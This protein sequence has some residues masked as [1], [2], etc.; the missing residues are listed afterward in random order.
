[1]NQSEKCHQ[2]EGCN[3]LFIDAFRAFQHKTT[4]ARNA[5]ILTHYHADHW[6]GL[7]RGKGYTGPSKIHCTPVTA[8]LLTE[9]HKIDASFIVTHE[10]ETTWKH[11]STEITFY[12]ANHCPGAA[13][14]F[15]KVFTATATATDKSSHVYRYHLHTG[16]MRFHQKFKSYPLIK[17]AVENRRLDILYLDTTYAKPKHTFLP[18]DEAIRKISSQVRELLGSNDEIVSEKK[19]SFFQPTGKAKS[20]SMKRTLV[21]LSCYSIGKEKVLWHSALQS[22]QLVYVNKAKHKMLECIECGSHVEE[23]NGIIRRC[24]LDKQ[25][26]D[27]HVIQ[28]G[29]AGSLHPYFQPNFDEC[30]LYAHRMNKGYTKVVAFIPTGWAESSKYNKENAISCK[31]VNLKELIKGSK[32]N[33]NHDVMQV[34]VR[35]C[36][37]SE[38]STYTELRD[39]VEF[40]R[41]K[42]IIPTVFSGEKDYIA[43]EKRFGDLID[44]QRAKQAFI[45]GIAGAFSKKIIGF[46]R[47]AEE[48]SV[49]HMKQNGTISNQKHPEIIAVAMEKPHVARLKKID[50]KQSSTSIKIPRQQENIEKAKNE[51]NLAPKQMLKV[52]D[53]KVAQLVNMG[54]TAKVATESLMSKK[55]DIERAIE[56]LLLR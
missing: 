8:N 32:I 25:Q 37:Y 30:A 12:D 46:K 56:W 24:T 18:Q 29:T 31:A 40:M 34:E 5:F 51:K 45:S 21:L 9:I 4:D 3:D 13:L 27:L 35:L 23:A 10:Y 38:H 14:L 55:N 48:S 20:A 53:S 22:N 39:C 1:M 36:A 16:D 26:S 41:P 15:C 7:P 42:Q 44:S 47:K 33:G 2:L 43:I 19:Q 11:G 54:F 6:T 17:E 50:A 52:D 28:M 49:E